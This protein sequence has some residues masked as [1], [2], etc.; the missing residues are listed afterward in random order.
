[1]I[2]LN[3]SFRSLLKV[4]RVSKTFD[5]TIKASIALQRKLFFKQKKETSP[6]LKLSDINTN[7]A[8][9]VL[10]AQTSPPKSFNLEELAIASLGDCKVIRQDYGLT[11]LHIYVRP[12]RR[13]RISFTRL[14]EAAKARHSSW[15]KMFL[16]DVKCKIAIKYSGSTLNHEALGKR[17]V[18]HFESLESDTM[19]L[20]A[21]RKRF[22]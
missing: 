17:M 9:Y 21:R 11:C 14:L 10:L 22:G 2:S 15:Q 3:L 1:M 6:D 7:P 5:N 13:G 18:H 20:T 8:F 19:G 4:N 12:T 16:T